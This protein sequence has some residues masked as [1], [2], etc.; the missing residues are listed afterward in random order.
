MSSS[1]EFR[2]LDFNIRNHAEQEPPEETEEDDTGRKTPK[3][4]NVAP[5]KTSKD[6]N[7]FEIQIFGINEVGETYS[8]VIE[9]F[10]PFFYVMVN[11]TWDSKKQSEF[12]QHIQYKMGPY[13]KN[14]ITECFLI[15]RR[16]LYGFDG[17]KEHKFIKLSFN[18]MSAL[19]KAKNL[20][21]SEYLQGLGL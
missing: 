10:S 4:P 3:R 20:W 14:T 12:L 16:K 15:K 7:I 8:V 9:G 6:L 13:Y 2:V 5:R 11:D 19:N 17:E 1:I 18:S 21:Y